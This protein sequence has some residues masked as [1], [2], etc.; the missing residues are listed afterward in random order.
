MAKNKHYKYER[1]KHLPNVIFSEFG[2]S[3][4]PCSYPWYNKS[5]EGMEKVLELGCGKG[6]HSLAF[7][8]ANS[9]RLCVGIDSKSH[10]MCVGAEKAI[11]EGLENIYF[12]RTRV[13]RIGEFFEEHSIH[14][15]WLTF[16]DPHLKNREVKCR[17]SA[18]PFLDVYASLLIPGGTVFLK[19]D[20]ELF[21]NYTWES[22]ALWGGNVIAESDNIHGADDNPLYARGVVSAFEKAAQAKGAAIKYLAFQLH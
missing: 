19:T 7:A 2:V 12:L 21:Y 14:E 18:T 10:R 3:L 13:E 8:A 16:P 4:P 1:V 9:T 11:A 20:N 5:Y 6:E 15:I 22:V 17:L